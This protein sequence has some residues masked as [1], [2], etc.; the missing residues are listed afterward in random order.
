MRSLPGAA[1]AA[2]IALAMPA[3][4]AATEGGPYAIDASVIAGGGTTLAGGAFV[5]DGTLAQPAASRLAASEFSLS[6]GFW[7]PRG[8]APD[9]IFSNGFDL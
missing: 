5:L 1:R 4:L 7:P 3:A 2:A 6:T 9:R 8:A